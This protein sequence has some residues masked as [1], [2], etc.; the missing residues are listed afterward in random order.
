MPIHF[1][2]TSSE[3]NNPQK[4]VIYGA[5]EFIQLYR[6]NKDTTELVSR[7]DKLHYYQ[8]TK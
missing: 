2:L 5:F 3:G 6:L 8:D 1:Q 4:P 7:A